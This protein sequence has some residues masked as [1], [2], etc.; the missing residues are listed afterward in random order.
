MTNSNHGFELKKK[1]KAPFI[2]LSVVVIAV[3]AWLMIKN[4]SSD[5]KNSEAIGFGHTLKVHYEPTMIGEKSLIEFANQHVAPD[6]GLTLEAVGVQDSVQGNRAVNDGQFAATI[7]QHQWWLKQ[8]NDANGFKLIPTTEI[9][10]WA[11]GIYSD[12]YRQV[13]ELPKGAKIALPSDLANQAQALW[14][15]QREGILTLKPEIEPRTARLKDIAEN[16]FEFHFTEIELLSIARS[17]DSVDAAIGYVAQFDAAKV[18]RS[19]GIL[20]PAAPRTF[21]G[22]LV[23]AEKSKDDPAILKLQ[24]V[25]SD[26][27]IEAYLKTTDDLNVKGIFTPVSQD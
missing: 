24:Q 25:F 3:L 17:L 13:S 14:L 26:P 8:V 18:P 21:A 10:Q 23:I 20:F 16:P 27:R 4:T 11:F 7:H 9:F 15:L 19:K 22:R 1:S 2:V 12:R 5:P 6:Y